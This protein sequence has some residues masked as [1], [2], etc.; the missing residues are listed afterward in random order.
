[1]IFSNISHERFS[2]LLRLTGSVCHCCFETG[3]YYVDKDGLKLI[4]YLMLVI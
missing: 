1:M 2:N 4:P 3:S